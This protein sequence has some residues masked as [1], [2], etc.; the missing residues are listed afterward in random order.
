MKKTTIL[1]LVLAIILSF[2]SCTTASIEEETTAIS[3]TTTELSED[4][5]L[6]IQFYNWIESV[7]YRKQSNLYGGLRP[8]YA[9]PVKNIIDKNFSQSSIE[10]PYFYFIE[11]LEHPEGT[12][13]FFQVGIHFE[14]SDLENEIRYIVESKSPMAYIYI[15]GYTNNEIESIVV[16]AIKKAKDVSDSFKYEISEDDDYCCLMVSHN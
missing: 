12:E 4:Q 9:D 15:N 5:E 3:S 10:D 11:Y 2:A 7:F 14:I 6:F 8:S 1:F 16:N 13:G